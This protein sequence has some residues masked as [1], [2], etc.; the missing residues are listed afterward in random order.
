MFRSVRW[1][2]CASSFNGCILKKTIKW[3]KYL[4]LYWVA[5]FRLQ[6]QY[7]QQFTFLIF[8]TC[9]CL[10]SSERITDGFSSA[11]IRPSWA[12]WST[13]RLAT[14]DKSCSSRSMMTTLDSRS[15]VRLIR[16]S[17]LRQGTWGFP[18][19]WA[20][21]SMFSSYLIQRAVSFHSWPDRTSNSTKTFCIERN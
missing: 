17:K 15:P 20:S 3:S 9:L 7:I 5:I 11:R 4:F 19:R 1:W 18:H 10:K 8:L 6:E 14:P 13:T 21:S 16:E 2:N 12:I